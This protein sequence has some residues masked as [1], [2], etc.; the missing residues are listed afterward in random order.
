MTKIMTVDDSRLVRSI[1]AAALGEHGYETVE[2][3]NGE[4]A[5]ELL[6]TDS[7]DLVLLD[8]MMPVMTD[9]QTCHLA[10]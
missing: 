4:Q 7:F 5:L 6:K 2:A 10:R 8:V 9:R 1:I 3:E